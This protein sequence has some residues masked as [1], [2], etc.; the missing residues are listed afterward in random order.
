MAADLHNNLPKTLILRASLLYLHHFRFQNSC[1]ALQCRALWRR[2]LCTLAIYYTACTS[3]T[4]VL[5]HKEKDFS[6]CTIQLS[7]PHNSRH[8]YDDTM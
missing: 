6:G 5:Q 2:C 1:F 4:V 7:F 8:A 3:K